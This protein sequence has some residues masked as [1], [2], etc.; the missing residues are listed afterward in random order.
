MLDHIL[1][2]KVLSPSIYHMKKVAGLP[3]NHQ[4]YICP[5]FAP[6]AFQKSLQNV[7]ERASLVDYRVILSQV[8]YRT[9][10]LDIRLPAFDRGGGQSQLPQRL[11]MN[12][13]QM[14]ESLTLVYVKEAE[15]TK[16]TVI[17]P[18]AFCPEFHILPIFQ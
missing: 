8:G 3:G 9:S 1:N 15:G 4:Q 16:A 14:A 12:H 10:T 18:F 6:P 5:L 11:P 7:S 17:M 13:F 2:L